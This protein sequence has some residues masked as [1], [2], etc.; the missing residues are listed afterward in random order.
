MA[1]ANG[2]R[3]VTADE[4]LVR[5]LGQR[6]QRSLRERVISLRESAGL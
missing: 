4:S 3:L 6:R 5:K 2:C 1:I